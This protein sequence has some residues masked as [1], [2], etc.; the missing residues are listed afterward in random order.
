[1]PWFAVRMIYE[2]SRRAKRGVFEERIV[3]FQAEDIDTAHALALED[4]RQYLEI[5]PKFK[6]SNH[7]EIYALGKANTSLHGAEIW[8]NLLVSPQSLDELVRNRYEEPVRD[9]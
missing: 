4:S 3:L 1:M 9:V 8:S 5:N 2:H 6:R 7:V